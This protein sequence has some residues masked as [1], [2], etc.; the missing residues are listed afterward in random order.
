MVATGATALHKPLIMKTIVVKIDVAYSPLDEERL[1]K[2][3]NY[4]SMRMML[5]LVNEGDELT[6][7]NNPV[8]SIEDKEV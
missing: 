4:L 3:I 6:A 2:R 1:L 7:I 5:G 8:V